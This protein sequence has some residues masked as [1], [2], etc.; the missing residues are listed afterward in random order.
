MTSSIDSISKNLTP[1]EIYQLKNNILKLNE[2][3]LSISSRTNKLLLN[4]DESQKTISE[5]LL[6]FSHIAYNLEE[7]INELSNKEFN[8]EV[9]TK[10]EKIQMLLENAAS[11]DNT[12]HQVL[13]YLGEWVDAASNTFESINDKTNEINDISEALSELRKSSPDKVALIELIEERFEEQQSRMDRL[14][15]KIDELTEMTKLNSNLSIVQKIDKMERMFN[16]LS[17]NIEKLTS[18]VD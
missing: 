9:A 8:A 2:D 16:S 6:A 5:G 3:I 1:A 15:A 17:V 4:S 14:E 12:F 11:M 18:Y 10:L 13:M 7:R